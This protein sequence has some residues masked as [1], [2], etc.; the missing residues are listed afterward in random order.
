MCIKTDTILLQYTFH[1]LQYFIATCLCMVE[2]YQQQMF[3]S[4]KF[5]K[6]DLMV[7]FNWGSPRFFNKLSLI[8]SLQLQ[9]NFEFTEL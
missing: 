1:Q 4:S 6:N 9:N 3:Q 5:N 7:L 8:R 2:I